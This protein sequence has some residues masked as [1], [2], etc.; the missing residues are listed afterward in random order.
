MVQIFVQG[1]DRV[2][3]TGGI[4]KDFMKIVISFVSA[5]RICNLCYEEKGKRVILRQIK[6]EQRFNY[7]KFKLF[8]QKKGLEYIGI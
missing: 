3:E 1:R 4:R 2:F 7:W 6:V 8:G 5:C